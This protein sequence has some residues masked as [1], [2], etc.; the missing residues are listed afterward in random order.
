MYNVA[1][2]NYMKLIVALKHVKG[3]KYMHVS[4]A[5]LKLHW[6][7][8]GLWSVNF[9]AILDLK[10]NTLDMNNFIKTVYVNFSLQNVF[11]NFH[12]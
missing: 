10:V 11:E 5:N 9:V 7:W 2:Y 12:Q 1:T 3:W 4:L 6:L 8:P